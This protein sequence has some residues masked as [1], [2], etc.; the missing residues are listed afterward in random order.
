MARRLWLADRDGGAAAPT[1]RL[2]DGCR[3]ACLVARWPDHR[4]DRDPPPGSPRSTLGRRPVLVEVTTDDYKRDGHPV[5]A[6]RTRGAIWVVPADGGEARA[7]TAG[8][9]TDRRPAWSPDGRSVAFLSDRGREGRASPINDLWRVD[10]ADGGRDG[11]P[12]T[13]LTDGSGPVVAFSWSPDGARIAML[14]HGQG[15]AQ[16]LGWRLRI[17]DADGRRRPATEIAPGR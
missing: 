14:G 10:A 7:L 17:V 9:A 12:P 5:G 8:T 15:S 3:G 11:E 13:R 4:P 6:G 16:G 1:R 2:A